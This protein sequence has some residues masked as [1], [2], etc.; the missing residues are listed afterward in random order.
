MKKVE[1]NIPRGRNIVGNFRGMKGYG[2]S[3]DL[4]HRVEN[5]RVS[6]E[7]AGERQDPDQE[8]P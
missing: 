4:S 7:Q 6:N 1:L 3:W 2:V 5:G 8:E